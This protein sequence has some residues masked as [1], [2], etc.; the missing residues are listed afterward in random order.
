QHE[1]GL[2]TSLGPVLMAAKG[3]ASPEV[4]ELYARARTLCQQGEDTEQILSVLAGLRV[5]YQVRGEHRTSQE[6]AEQVLALAQRSQ[7]PTFLLAAYRGLT[8]STFTLGELVATREYA[9]RGLSLYDPQRHRLLGA[10][11][12]GTDLGV[13][14]LSY[15]SYTLWALGYPTQGE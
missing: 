2:L 4:G 13:T 8:A 9:E 1:L 6:L 11:Y 15:L 14:C 5:F 3:F 12:G 7:D 10:Q